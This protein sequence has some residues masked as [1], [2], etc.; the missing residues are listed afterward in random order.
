MVVVTNA[1]AYDN[2]VFITDVGGE[3]PLQA[4]HSNVRLGW[5]WLEVRNTLA[6]HYYSCKTFEVQASVGEMLFNG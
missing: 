5:K 6:Y 1:L 3:T 2:L 4:L